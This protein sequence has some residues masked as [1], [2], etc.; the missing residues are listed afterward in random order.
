VALD[1]TDPSPT[2]E[3]LRAVETTDVGVALSAGAGCGKTSVLTA[4]FLSHL[5]P[6]KGEADRSVE[7]ALRRVVAITFTE[8][9]A[10][11]MRDRIRREV[12]KRVTRADTDAA[13]ERWLAIL[14]RLEGAQVSTIHSFCG[15][16]LRR[17]AVEAGLDPQFGLLEPNEA[18]V[19]LDE[20]VEDE[21]RELLAAGDDSLIGLTVDYG[22]NGVR[23][24]LGYFLKQR[25]RID[26]DAWQTTTSDELLERWKEFHAKF[27]FER[28]RDDF[29]RSVEFR[30]VLR[31]IEETPPVHPVFIERCGTIAGVA[32]T[33]AE[34]TPA[35]LG[36]RLRIVRENALLTGKGI[37]RNAW[38]GDDELKE[39]YRSA[40]ENLRDLIDKT[41]PLVVFDAA[42]ARAAA[43]CS[44][45]FVRLARPIV[46]RYDER[47]R[48]L[49][50]LD[51][52]DLLLKVRDLL[53]DPRHADLRKRLA[54]GIDRLLVDECQDTDP[55]QKELIEALV[56]DD[57]SRRKL[58]LVGDFKQSIYRF[59]RADPEIFVEWERRTPQSGRL[60]LTMNFRSQPEILAFANLLFRDAMPGY[61]VLQAKREQVTPGP[62]IEFLWA[63]ADAGDGDLDTSVGA[64][65][66]AEADWIARRIRE[67]LDSRT[68]LVPEQ[69][70]GETTL[71]PVEPGDIVLLFRAFSDVDLYEQALD[72]YGVDYYVVGGKAFYGQQEVFDLLNLLR[73]VDSTCD[74]VA[75]AG[76]L[77]SP[78]FSLRDDTLFLLAQ[79][80]GGLAGGLFAPSLTDEITGDERR[81]TEFAATVL[82]DLRA[83]KNRL[84]IAGLLNDILAR[85]A[86]D[87]IL[88]GEFLGERK[89]ANLRK[90]VEEARKF[91]QSNVATLTDFIGWLADAVAQQPDEAPAAVRAE[92]SPVVRLMTIH[93]AKG[94]EFPVVIVPDLQRKLNDSR[95]SAA[96]D[97]RL[98][99]A[100]RSP[101]EKGS[102]GI[103]LF[104]S[105]ERAA[106]EQ[107]SVRLFY[108]AVTR[109][110]DYL[111]MSSGI[112]PHDDRAAGWRALVGECFDLATGKPLVAAKDG[113]PRPAVRVTN[114]IPP[115]P[116]DVR[117][118]SR[119]PNW[120][121]LVEQAEATA[122]RGL[123][124]AVD[125]TPIEP[126]ADARRRFSF[127]RLSGKLVRPE[128]RGAEPAATST[129][130]DDETSVLDGAVL[131]TL[132]HGV[133][134]TLEFSARDFADEARVAR[135]VRRQAERLRGRADP[136]VIETYRGEATAIVRRFLATPRAA[137]LAKARNLY[138][139][140]EFLMTWLPGAPPRPE[141]PVLQG[142]LDCLYDD[143]LGKL[144][145]VDYKTH[146]VDA[147]NA[148]AAAEA[149]RGQLGIYALATE[150]ILGRAPDELVVSFI[151][152]G[153][154]QA[155]SW[156]DEARR[157][158]IA[159]ID[160]ALKARTP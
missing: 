136:A 118:R 110:K 47:K 109:A 139:E 44:L 141:A 4:R 50:R 108:V 6:V 48:D 62:T 49:A 102:S 46:A 93:Q 61:A 85:T 147:R 96:Y 65:R 117:R 56:G 13:A 60:P 3:Q 10:R 43:E 58:F 87:A 80:D 26:F 107:E 121:K 31:L 138:R 53:C 21:L 57:V 119:R 126:R 116:R 92:K 15:T 52:D 11:E 63:S 19:L 157:R 124:A 14:R 145:L 158:V 112:D 106:D 94:L 111:I 74:D 64:R 128:E 142:F 156:N 83:V 153:V 132:V 54:T 160:A 67:V 25:Y 42:G 123:E 95:G 79:H 130:T 88:A 39:A 20:L 24:I 75:L 90:L 86:Y 115:K 131:G 72:A 135:A 151:Q 17:H 59:R 68:P 152:T 22:L 7:A 35:Q 30:D 98:G 45:R 51:F 148:T 2:P 18:A 144:R 33:L 125:L 9:A 8:R 29:C 89:L 66:T 113:E 104:R 84:T 78:F 37:P 16:L 71:R 114:V 134:A 97:E 69:R 82:R 127:S 28:L 70:G 34:A 81:R 36:E 55:L 155:F 40:F 41:L 32:A 146:R 73:A 122:E 137:A 120:P 76:A 27:V 91:D 5:E 154:E 101:V 129:T 143:D 150:Q 23:D 133:L 103:T 100:V 99:P 77:R 159:E 12:R 38:N 140:L 105:V 149:Y 1:L